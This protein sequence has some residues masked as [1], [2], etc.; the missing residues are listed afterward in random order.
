VTGRAGRERGSA[1]IA[2]T[3][4]GALAVVIASSIAVRFVNEFR[5]VDD[6][7][8]EVRA[9][10][11]AIGHDNYVLSRTAFSGSCNSGSCPDAQRSK[12]AQTYL[13]EVKALRTWSYPEVGPYYQFSVSPAANKDP[14]PLGGKAGSLMIKTTFAA[15]TLDALRIAGKKPL[16]PIEFRYCVGI[17]DANAACGSAPPIT[18]ELGWHHVTSVHRPI[19]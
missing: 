8:A 1:T 4:L 7:L 12:L 13:D 2:V 16:R 15:G 3:L 11:A 10:W 18:G 14:T 17:T 9:Y 6:S 5:A 19:S